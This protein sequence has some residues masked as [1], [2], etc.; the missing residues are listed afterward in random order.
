MQRKNNASSK[1]PGKAEREGLSLVEL[2]QMFPTNEA[3]EEWFVKSLWPSGVCCPHCGSVAITERKSRKPQRYHCRDCRSYFSPKTGT[4]MQ[5]SNLSY[6]TWAFAIYLMS[7]N[8]KGVS[9]MKLHRDLKITQKSAW[10]LAHRI[11]EHWQEKSESEQFQGPVEIDEAYIG[12]KEK[13]KHASKKL[14][15]GRGPVGKAAVV[16][17]KDR[18]TKKVSATPMASVTQEAVGELVGGAV[19]EGASIYTDESKV[20]DKLPNREAVNHTVG[21][22]VRKQA[23]TNGIESFWSMLKR[24]YYGTY[25][26]MS[27]KHLARYVNEFAGRHNIR[28]LDTLKQM[29]LVAYRMNGK[30]LRFADLVK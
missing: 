2:A 1:G 19:K 21:E 18:E 17:I 27:A 29:S 10:H 24:G 28:N 20:Y 6:Q 3:A 23:H 25:H 9:S 13:N 22:Y 16:G 15:A 5:G 4:L 12:G 14:K 30:R 7:T 8:L 11:R 26:K